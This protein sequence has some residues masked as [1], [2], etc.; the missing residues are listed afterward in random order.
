MLPAH[1]QGLIT[2]SGLRRV[3]RLELER[4]LAPQLA[5]AQSLTM[6]ISESTLK[7]MVTR[8]SEQLVFQPVNEIRY[9]FTYQSG[10][11]LEPGYP[12]LYY[13]RQRQRTVSPN[14]TAVSALGE[15]IAGFLAQRLYKCRKLG[16]P[17]HD[18]PDIVMEGGGS[19]FLVESKAT[20]KS[21]NVIRDEYTTSS[22]EWPSWSSAR[23]S[24][25]V[26]Q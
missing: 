5:Y 1:L 9:W 17:N 12:P 24:W 22:L 26:G 21:E 13:G 10:A 7:R 16:R 8:Y 20:L 2:G 18:Y 23:G 15:A 11:Y 3:L 4:Q 19:T 14:K 25:T 6:T